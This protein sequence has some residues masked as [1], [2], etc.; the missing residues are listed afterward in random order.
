ML[1]SFHVAFCFL[2]VN[3]QQRFQ[4]LGFCRFGDE[5]QRARQFFFRSMHLAQLVACSVYLPRGRME[6][7]G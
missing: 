5:R 1:E 4:V 3:T 7:M 2:E 6:L